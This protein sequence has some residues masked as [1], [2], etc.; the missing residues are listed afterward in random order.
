MVAG[1]EESAVPRRE[2]RQRL[3]V[4]GKLSHAAVDEVAGDGDHVRAESV[5]RID[6]P[7]EVIALDRRA[8]VEVADLGDAEAV[9]RRRQP[10]DR[11]VD[12]PDRARAGAR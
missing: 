5:H 11:N 6:D 7:L 9:Q 2:P 3:G 8:D 12:A 4:P 10:G 1:D